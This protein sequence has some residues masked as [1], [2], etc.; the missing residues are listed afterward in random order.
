MLHYSSIKNTQT[1]AT[2]LTFIHGAGGNSSIWHPQ[3]RFFKRFYNL[4]LIDLRGHGKSAV[5]DFDEHY[6]FENVTEDIIQVL[7]KEGIQ[8]SHFVGISLGSILIQKLAENHPQ[9]MF[10]MILAGAILNLNLRSKCL[11]QLGKLTQSI[12]PFIWIYSFF[13]HV[14]MPYKNHRKARSL[15]I[16]E[17]KKLSQQEFLRWYKLTNDL[18]PHLKRFRTKNFKVPILYIM[19]NQDYMFLPFVKKNVA[20]N[21]GAEL[22]VLNKCGHVVNIEKPQEFNEGMLHFLQLD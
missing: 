6:T 11:M 3:V 20:V 4:L 14:I 10:K 19:G 8:K 5:H 18:L 9:R 17:A 2:W 12:L 13:A 22:L 1:N 15:F 16:Q 21:T 7:D